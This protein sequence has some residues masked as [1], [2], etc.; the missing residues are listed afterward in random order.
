MARKVKKGKDS[1]VTKAGVPQSD[2]FYWF[3]LT[4]GADSKAGVKVSA[5]T[6]MQSSAVFACVRMLSQDLAKLRP[7]VARALPNRGKE[8]DKKHPLARLLRRPNPWQT[9]FEFATQM[10]TALVLRGNAYAAILRDNRGQAMHLVPLNPDSLALWESED[11]NL[12]W[13]IVKTGYHERAWLK[14]FDFLIPY[15][16][17]L[18]LSDMRGITG[19]QGL[20]TI[21]MAVE[22]VGLS[23]AQE[24]LASS[25]TGNRAQPSGIL[26]TEAR[27]SKDE[28]ERMEA[29]WNRLHKGVHQ[30]GKT[31]VFERGLKWIPLAMTAEDMEF[32]ASRRYQLEEIARLFR[33]PLHM[34]GAA[35][36]KNSAAKTVEQAGQDYINL[37][38]STYTRLWAEKLSMMFDLD[39]GEDP[40]D[41]GWDYSIL[42]QADLATRVATAKAAVNGSLWTPNEGRIYLGWNPAEDEQADKLLFPNNTEPFGSQAS[43]TAPTDAGRP[44]DD[45]TG[46]VEGD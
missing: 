16:D 8:E 43:G 35:A 46:Q 28:A 15:A 12:F 25:W 30:A 26:S 37:T 42:V 29:A 22:S 5:Y 38:L 13:H 34:L 11:G 44:K 23:L 36:D 17:V 24:Q 33:V 39:L 20:D 1:L 45:G 7:Y 2:N 10:Q 9:W 27:L 6:A 32:L 18:H 3:G 14:D 21:G 19:L 4:G 41:I 40:L 31:A